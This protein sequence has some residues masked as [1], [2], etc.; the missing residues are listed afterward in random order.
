VASFFSRLEPRRFQNAYWPT[1]EE[2]MTAKE[3]IL[4]EG[5]EGGNRN[6][7]PVVRRG[8]LASGER[9]KVSP[10]RPL[11]HQPACLTGDG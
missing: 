10:D 5:H 9:G 4:N 8:T 3:I 7:K 2:E 11:E 1:G 6:R